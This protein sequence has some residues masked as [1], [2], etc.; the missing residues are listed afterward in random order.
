MSRGES[1]GVGGS[2]EASIGVL[3]YHGA[4]RVRVA[5]LGYQG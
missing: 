3:G 1:R 4:T 5:G 2:R